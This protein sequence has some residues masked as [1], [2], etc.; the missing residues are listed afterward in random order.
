M[1]TAATVVTVWWL[2]AHNAGAGWVQFVGVLVF[3]TLLV[4]VAGPAVAVGRVRIQVSA[5][6]ADAMA[7]VPFEVHLLASNRVRIR[8]LDP[9]GS[10]VFAGPAGRKDRPDIVVVVPP[11]RGVRRAVTLE[12]ASAAPFAL[13]WWRRTAVVALPQDL[14]VAPRIGRPEPQRQTGPEEAGSI[15]ARPVADAGLPR[16]AR[17]YR[18]GDHRR[19]VHWRVTAHAGSMMVKEL[20]NPTGRAVVVVVALP[21]DPDEAERAAERGLGAVVDLLAEGAT[22]VLQTRESSGVVTAPVA[23]RR[24]AGRRLARAISSAEGP[25]TILTNA[26]DATAAG[27]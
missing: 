26:T 27:P 9:P 13:Q 15:V 4:G 23:D 19:A 14:H 11:H 16:G 3:G 25:R 20:E 2:V 12:V 5:A 1:I 21:M 17:P 6:P 22:V 10:E 24:H 7:G 8:P 18:P